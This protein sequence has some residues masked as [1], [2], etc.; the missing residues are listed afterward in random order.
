VNGTTEWQQGSGLCA[1][2]DF[3]L[4]RVFRALHPLASL[5][6]STIRPTVRA[7]RWIVTVQARKFALGCALPNRRQSSMGMRKYLFRYAMLKEPAF[8]KKSFNPESSRPP[9]I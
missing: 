5:Q 3:V 4:Q 6:Q 1:G 7:N 9:E 2:L 8:A